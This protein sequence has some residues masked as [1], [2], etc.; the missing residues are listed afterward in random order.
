MNKKLKILALVVAVAVVASIGAWYVSQ[1]DTEPTTKETRTITD[2]AGRTVEIPAEVNSV[3]CT[4]PPT[5]MIVYMLSPDKLSG[6][7][8]KPNDQYVPSK[9]KDL[10]VV[11]GWFGTKTGN[12]ENFI[13]MHPD[14]V[15]EGFNTQGDFRST[16]NERQQKLSGIPVV[17]VDNT[18]N[19][20]EYE[21]PIRFIGDLLG[22][23]E[24]AAELISFYNRVRDEVNTVA[25]RIPE[26]EKRGVYYAE[27]PKGLMTDPKGSQHSQLIELC[28]GV[29][30]AQCPIKKGYGR[31]EVS[32]EQVL[33]WDPDVIIAGDPTFYEKIYSNPLWQ[34]I[35]AVKNHDVYLTP[36]SPF[37]WFDR[38]PGVNRII[39]IPWTA[40]MLYPE[41]FGDMDLSS[42]TKEFY[43][44]FYHYDLSD[45]EVY[46]I[47]HPH[48]EISPT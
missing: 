44:K 35:T 40:K 26:S 21:A 38:P 30:V 47:L 10:P 14:I 17:G 11:G 43:S 27:G 12:Y 45:E 22:E 2:M 46:E 42:L 25:S 4:S 9:Y 6:W 41:K 15:L 36:L 39:G 31:A 32:I 34:N 8:F 19:A 29:N 7:N 5:T 33:N 24:Q 18:V 16:I 48:K 23:E 37:C 28:G 3:L 1:Q 20:T 13:S